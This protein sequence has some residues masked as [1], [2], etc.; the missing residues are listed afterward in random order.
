MAVTDDDALADRMRLMS[1]HGMSKDAW[2]RYTAAGSWYYEI[3]AP[4]FKYNLTDIAAALGRVQL[5]RAE[6]L[7][8]A[9]KQVVANYRRALAGIPGLELP[10]EQANRQHSWHLF[11]IRLDLDI[12]SRGRDAFIDGLKER[13][14]GASVHWM[15][16]HMQPYYRETY[17]LVPGD[18]PVAA[19]LWPRLVTLPLYPGM[20]SEEVDLVADAIRSIHEQCRIS[21]RST[22]ELVTGD[23][24][25]LGVTGQLLR[26]LIKCL[27][28]LAGSHARTRRTCRSILGDDVAKPS[29]DQ[30]G[31][32]GFRQIV[33]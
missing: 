27:D 32:P 31:V 24:H 14:I 8:A 10:I 25:E 30:L 28:R 5:S 16:L 23:C 9:R 7:W 21:W 12:W 11:S 15:P 26:L 3:V 33:K 4:G 19:A 13:G 29:A 17:G 6:E 1:L 20:T 22:A 2:K 18:F